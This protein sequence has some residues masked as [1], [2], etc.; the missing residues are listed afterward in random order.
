MAVSRTA[1]DM[2]PSVSSPSM[3]NSGKSTMLRITI[4]DTPKSLTFQLDGRLVGAWVQELETCW[5]QALAGRAAAPV[6]V[7][8]SEVTF[9]D[10]SGKQLLATMHGQGAELSASGCLMKAIVA[11]VVRM[12]SK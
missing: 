2:R 8:L 9:V 11:E 6:R 1:C 12:S 3:R 4:H 5:R 10:L 7:D